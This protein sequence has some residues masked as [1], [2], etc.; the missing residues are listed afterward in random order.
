[1]PRKHNLPPGVSV[2]FDSRGNP[3]YYFRRQGHQKVRLRETPGTDA[4]KDEVACARLGI[5]HEA[6]AKEDKGAARP[7]VINGSLRWLADEYERRNRKRITPDLMERRYRMLMEICD[8]QLRSGKKRGDLPFAQM[9]RKHV[10]DARDELRDTPGAQN[11]I[12]KALSSMF[13]WAVKSGMLA[14]NPCAGIERLHSGEG[15]HT[16]TVDEVEQFEAC[17]P[18]G[19]T[20]RLALHL[21]LF[22]GFRL[23]T[24]AIVGRQHEENGWLVVRPNKTAKSSGVVVSIPI[25]PMLG[26]TIAQSRCGDLAFLMNDYGRP[27]TVD[28]LGNRFRKWCDAAQLPHCTA[29]GLRKAGATIAAENGATD[30]ELMAIFG[31]VTKQQTTLYTQKANRKR[32]AGN[33]IHKLIPERKADKVVPAISGVG[34]NGT[35]KPKKSSKING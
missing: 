6:K 21:G 30:E 24:L 23:Q 32:I 9:Q 2:D 10:I 3:R 7:A 8:S 20:A 16:W 31:W 11:N 5:P 34:K 29:H 26:E 17:H 18:A 1:M 33:A 12:I 25:L 4:F 28:G 19:S 22:T 15:F 14:L 35:K 13:A 27:F